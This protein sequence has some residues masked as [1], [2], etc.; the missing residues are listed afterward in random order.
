MA[1]P[2][3]KGREWLY[4]WALA[5]A[6]LL[7]TKWPTV[8][9]PHYWDA[10]GCYVAQSHYMAEAKLDWSRYALPYLRPPLYTG[11]LAWLIAKV[12]ARRELLHI[13]TLAWV[14][15]ALP[16]TFF[17]A[18]RLGAAVRWAW[19]A[20]V[21]CLL[22]P[23]FFSQAGMAQTD[24]PAAALVA[25]AWAIALEDRRWRFALVGS[26]AVLTK[27]S[28]YFICLPAGLLFYA[29]ELPEGRRIHVGAAL[30]AAITPAVPCV[31]LALWLVAHRALTGRFMGED[32][33]AAV[34]NLGSTAGAFLHNF[35]EGGRIVLLAFL[36]LLLVRE[37]RAPTPGLD[38]AELWTTTLAV[39][40]LPI[41]FGAGQ[42]RYM[43]PSLPMMCVLAA[44]GVARLGPKARLAAVIA[45]P[46]LSVLGWFGESWH[47]NH[48]C[49]LES[50]LAYRKLLWHQV[51]AARALA[52]EKPRRVF[53][54]FPMI[55]LLRAPPGDGHLPEIIANQPPR[56]D[57]E[58]PELCTF[59]YIIEA[60]GGS[61][62][63]ALAKLRAANAVTLWRQ[64]GERGKVIGSR[65]GTPSWAVTD[66]TIRVYRV[67]CPPARN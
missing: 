29:R 24:L 28:S 3:S 2:L 5:F 65:P 35:I 53:S 4:G 59:D 15:L 19:F 41:L 42:P 26:L 49:H 47:T 22:M 61:V 33:V 21:L 51:E 57:E 10:L 14:A 25:V 48:G 18:R 12:S 56:G 40:A 13:V 6:A 44:L 43:L 8:D 20:A 52:A 1:P 16:G 66:H 34:F 27:E 9:D 55:S 32:H 63:K 7:V 60:D 58:L 11:A 50:N 23:V 62:D 30:R 46:A 17:I 31:A 37:R 45:L 38:R 39:V 64:F 67:A 54:D 36:L